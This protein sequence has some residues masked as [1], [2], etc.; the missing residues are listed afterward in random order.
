M[1]TII[2][3][4][5]FAIALP[6]F[7]APQFPDKLDD[8]QTGRKTLKTCAAAYHADKTAGRLDGL[9]WISKGGGY[10]S[11]CAKHMKVQSDKANGLVD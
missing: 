7:A 6:A 3:L 10:W 5:S 9:A 2:I 4:S 1:R 11:Q 8:T